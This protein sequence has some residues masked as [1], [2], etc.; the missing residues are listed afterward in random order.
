MEK[1]IPLKDMPNIE[2]ISS[3]LVLQGEA[4]IYVDDFDKNSY[5]LHFPDVFD[6]RQC[7]EAAFIA[8]KFDD[9]EDNRRMYSVFLVKNSELIK[10]F[11]TNSDGAYGDSEN[12]YRHYIIYDAIDTIIEIITTATPTIA[13]KNDA[14]IRPYKIY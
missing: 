5:E 14:D 11:I 9:K 10:S 1:L 13:R 6:F 3:A 2:Y 12:E 7:V 4:R 8:R